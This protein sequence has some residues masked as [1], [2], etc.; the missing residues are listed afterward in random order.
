MW[1]HPPNLSRSYSTKYD[2]KEAIRFVKCM[3]SAL[4]KDKK[5]KKSIKSL[6]VQILK[7]AIL[8]SLSWNILSVGISFL[9]KSG[10]D[11]INFK[12]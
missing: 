1:F 11:W 4:T 12:I 5:K 3:P 9:R 10:S 6:Q 7:I 2:R 8:K